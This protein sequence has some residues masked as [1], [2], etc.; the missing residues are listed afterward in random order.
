MRL[1][2]GNPLSSFNRMGIALRWPFTSQ[3]AFLNRVIHS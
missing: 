2:E 1:N 3:D